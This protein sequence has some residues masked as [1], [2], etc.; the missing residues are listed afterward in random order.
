MLDVSCVYVNYNS[1]TFTVKAVESLI[2][3]T[4]DSVR[5]E[6]IVVDNGSNYEDYV[7]LKTGL[8]VLNC[9]HVKLYRSRINTGFG[10][11]NMLGVNFCNPSSYYAFINND[12]LF[13]QENTLLDLMNFMKST[14][15]AGVCGPQMM[16]Q[17]LKRIVSLD[18]KATPLRQIVGKN[19]LETI[20]KKKYPKRK[21]V[22]TQPVAC[23]YI[24]GSFIFTKASSFNAV[25]GFDNALFLYYEESDLS[26]RIFKQ[27][28]E[29][30]YHYPMQ[31]Y[32]HYQGKSTAKN[33]LIKIEQKISLLYLIKKHHGRLAHGLL[34]FYYTVRYGFGGIFNSS[35]RNLFV[36]LLKG[37]SL[38]H[39]LRLK[40]VIQEL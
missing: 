33:V 24:Q 2:K 36:V 30:T 38:N 18:H 26:T 39:S 14:Q 3:Y 32:I 16:S 4:K 1:A 11:G 15:D 23:G 10:S 25:G 29:K 7:Q 13:I 6:V 20:N 34:L 19:F 35:K 17:D 12:T 27:L 40:Q 31:E 37:A 8:E 22:Y 9:S 5:Y 28:K 21:K